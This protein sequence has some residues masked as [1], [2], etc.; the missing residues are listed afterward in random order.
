MFLRI[1]RR[2]SFLSLIVSFIFVCCLISLVNLSL[3]QS[4]IKWDLFQTF[5]QTNDIEFT[6][7]FDNVTGADKYIVPN[8]IHFI[9]FKTFELNFIDY[10]VLKAAMR[11]HKPDK[12]Y[13][14]TNV[15]EVKYEGKYW[16]LVRKDRDLWSRIEVLYLEA[17]TEIF[18][19]KLNEG[20]RFYHGGDIGRIR[21]LMQY[22]GIYLDNDCFVIRSLDKYRNF[23]CAINWDENQ[24]IGSQ[25]I[26]AHKNARF[27]AL[28][29]DSYRHYRSE[30]WYYNAGER[31]TVEILYR[32]PQLVH[33]VK[34]DFGIITDVSLNLYRNTSKPFEWR[35]LDSIHLLVN[36]RFYL[37][38]NYNKTPTFNESNIQTYQYPFGEMAREVLD[39]KP[40]TLSESPSA[41]QHPP[42]LVIDLTDW[43]EGES[44]SF[45]LNE[46][47]IANT[48]TIE[49]T[50]NDPY[51]MHVNEMN[52]QLLDFLMNQ[53]RPYGIVDPDSITSTT[54]IPP[55]TSTFLPNAAEVL[56]K[57]LISNGTDTDEIINAQQM[58]LFRDYVMQQL[59]PL[60]IVGSSEKPITSSTTVTQ[61][62]LQQ[63]VSQNP[64]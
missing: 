55:S 16:D 31:P 21:V 46:T 34:G 20:W 40:I 14:H 43:T 11:N 42:Q 54:T 33:R 60:G 56:M 45:A 22:G 13:I 49:P 1:R 57:N 48:S 39:M 61:V 28:W 41:H 64:I 27:L 24:F 37:D 2:S 9:R 17:P 59:M 36:H 44:D 25:T 47:K 6:D 62:P 4:G 52:Q 10:V 50:T 5:E 12:F 53:L 23:E 7:D 26:I 35:S 18:G 30:K 51:T 58:Q 38:K 19:Q 8:I 29:L 63:L 3:S 32:H 15:L